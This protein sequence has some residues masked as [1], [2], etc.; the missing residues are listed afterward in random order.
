MIAA[1]EGRVRRAGSNPAKASAGLWTVVLAAGGGRRYGGAKLLVQRGGRS[2]LARAAAGAVV[3]TGPRTVVV[4]GANAARLVGELAGLPV[5]VVRNRRWRE[6]M[7]TSIAAGIGALPRSARGAVILLADQF[8]VG[9]AE[10]DS[11]VAAWRRSPQLPAAAWFGGR[12]GPPALFPRR[13]FAELRGLRGDL[14]ARALL[15]GAGEALTRVDMPAAAFDLD[16]P[17]D[18]R[19]LA[20]PDH[21]R[22]PRRG[23]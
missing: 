23:L 1:G 19:A 2:L 9:P 20:R 15:R 16:H 13:W 14:G 8:A 21:S 12:A 17:A 7:S 6:G 11:L 18:R 22:G 10:L 4:L 3:L 5:C